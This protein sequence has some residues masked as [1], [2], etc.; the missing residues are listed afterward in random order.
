MKN[1]K[2]QQKV[3]GVILITLFI[4]GCNASE[5]STTLPPTPPHPP[6]FSPTFTQLPPFPTQTT[7]VDPLEFV[8]IVQVA[9]DDTTQNGVFIRLGYVPALDRVVAVFAT[10]NL[11]K[12][13]NGC[14][15]PAHVYKVFTV[16]MQPDGREGVF[17]CGQGDSADLFVENTL[18]DVHQALVDGTDGWEIRKYDI[19]TWKQLAEV[20]YPLSPETHSN[21]MS[22]AMVNRVLDV[23]SL[24]VTSPGAP[25]ATHH[26]FFSTD[27]QFINQK[28]L[29]DTEN[30]NGSSTLM[31]DDTI[32]F[33]TGTGMP[34]DI[35]VAKYDK[36]WNYLG[37]KT[38]LHNGTWS[39]GSAFD[40][41][42]FYVAYMY[43]SY[44]VGQD[45]LFDIH[46][47]TFDRDWNLINDR[48]ITHYTENDSVQAW[49]PWILLFENQLYVSYD[50]Y[51]IDTV[52]HKEL[53][54]TTQA[55]IALFE[56]TP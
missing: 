5:T 19:L 46:L 29:S 17:N 8:K 14:T 11:A 3:F 30:T 34:G 18:Y 4:G 39:E 41:H 54:D 12:P 2:L 40:G 9:P 10:Y 49:R 52:N 44:H 31:I 16:D 35:I 36:D 26:N 33:I 32:Y 37:T 43:A 27:L 38:I 24:F 56:L 28:I 48:A 53:L 55:Y 42:H 7:S 6:L 23:S 47:A 15:G 21:D 13:E 20:Q 1:P 25:A 45:Y 51:K 22:I 50:V